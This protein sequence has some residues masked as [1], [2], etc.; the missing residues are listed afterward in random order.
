[1]E[2]L[3]WDKEDIEDAINNLIKKKTRK[4][5]DELNK[6]YNEKR[7]LERRKMIKKILKEK[8]ELLTIELLNKYGFN[9]KGIELYSKFKKS[10]PSYTKPDTKNDG[11]L[12][13]YINT[14]LKVKFTGRDEMEIDDLIKAE[15]YLDVVQLE[16]RRILHGIQSHKNK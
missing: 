4:K 3:G 13:I 7:P 14:K 11:V 15:E 2:A 8:I 6:I 10:L 5:S 9:E 12:V 16:L 1:M